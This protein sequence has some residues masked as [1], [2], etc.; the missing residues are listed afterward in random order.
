MSL[1]LGCFV[2]YTFMMYNLN[3][4]SDKIDILSCMENGLN[5]EQI[6]ELYKQDIE[7]VLT[8]TDLKVILIDYFDVDLNDDGHV[9]KIVTIRSP[10]HSSSGGDSLDFLISDNSGSYT[11]ISSLTIQ[12]YDQLGNDDASIY[13]SNNK[14]NGYYDIIISKDDNTDILSFVNGEYQKNI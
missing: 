6:K 3:E 7:D 13:I 1:L 11:K 5:N 10:L 8:A 2:F 4:V 9:D 14:T 12:L